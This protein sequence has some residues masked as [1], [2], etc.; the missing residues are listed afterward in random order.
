MRA[1]PQQRKST[2]LGTTIGIVAQGSVAIIDRHPRLLEF[3]AKL[4]DDMYTTPVLIPE[5]HLLDVILAIPAHVAALVA[6]WSCPKSNPFS[7]RLRNGHKM[8]ETKISSIMVR[9]CDHSV[10]RTTMLISIDSVES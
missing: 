9:E 4:A 2:P 10:V 3:R 6:P 1:G 8:K 7:R 5:N